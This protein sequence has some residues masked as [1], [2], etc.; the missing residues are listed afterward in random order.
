MTTFLLVEIFVLCVFESKVFD[1]FSSGFCIKNIQTRQVFCFLYNNNMT[2]IK[3]F[4]TL[5]LMFKG[6]NIER[7]CS[8]LRLRKDVSLLSVFFS[9][10]NEE[11]I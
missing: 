10:F 4:T 11:K 9:T 6:Q 7:M 2:A 8:E 3:D 5:D 1:P